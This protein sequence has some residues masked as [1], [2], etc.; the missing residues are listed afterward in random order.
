ML[1]H[2]V[3]DS[4]AVLEQWIDAPESIAALSQLVERSAPVLLA[5]SHETA[6]TPRERELARRLVE[7][8]DAL[9]A[10]CRS[11]RHDLAQLMGRLANR[12]PQP[13]AQPRI[14]SD[15]A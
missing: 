11:S 14:L 10:K 15:V 4:E 8:N 3:Q 12:A 1:L 6:Q 2:L 9:L 7:V 5:L 13:V